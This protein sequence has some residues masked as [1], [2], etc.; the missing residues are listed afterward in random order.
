MNKIIRKKIGY[1]FTRELWQIESNQKGQG[2]LRTIYWGAKQVP[3]TI[4]LCDSKYLSSSRRK[5]TTYSLI[6]VSG[7]KPVLG[8]LVGILTTKGKRGPIGGAIP[9]FIDIIRT[10][11]SQGAIVFV[12]TPDNVDWQAETIQGY[13]YVA[14]QKSW[15]KC[16]F[17]LPNV[18]YNRVPRR[19]LEKK[20]LVQ[21]C[22]AKFIHSPNVSLFNPSF[23]NKKTLFQLLEKERA[24]LPYLPQ[25]KT[26]LVKDDLR[27]MLKEHSEIYLKPTLGKAG[28]GILKIVRRYADSKYL[29]YFQ[30][31][32][33]PL[34]FS[35]FN[36]LWKA[37]KRHTISSP[38]ILQ[39]AIKLATYQGRPYD[40]R[41]LVQKTSN[42]NWELT[43]IGIRVAGE[44]RITTH[45]PRGG[46]IESADHV[47]SQSFSKEK[48]KKVKDQIEILAVSIARKLEGH[49]TL[50]GEMSMDI[51]IDH[52]GQ[53]WFFEANS[54]PMKFDEP[55]IR[56]KSLENLIGFSQYLSFDQLKNEVQYYHA[57]A[58]SVL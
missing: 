26:L 36:S 16:T 11:E 17:P 22:I 12:F 1:D 50:L 9:N 14:S 4:G 25:T 2:K 52:T 7:N 18:V 38:Y 42:G 48:A 45:V 29:L 51:G 30:Q 32:Q 37:I 39:K 55:E 44:N 24:I 40:A 43:G 20:P 5:Y 34:T 57:M 23:F 31:K 13:L 47:L 10:A 56:K 35:N 8:P 28:S 6:N 58:K 3:L 54:K 33:T 21:D 19:D 41:V 53:L 27:E 49:F 46:S 15:K